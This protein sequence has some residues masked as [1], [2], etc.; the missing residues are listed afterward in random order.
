MH[1]LFELFFILSLVILWWI[2]EWG[3]ISIAIENYAGDSQAR[4]LSI[5][6][7]IIISILVFLYLNPHLIK[8]LY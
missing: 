3:I 7:G 6:I 8:H 2:A 4:E 1:K 5:H